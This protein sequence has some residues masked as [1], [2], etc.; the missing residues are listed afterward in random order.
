MWTSSGP[1]PRRDKYEALSQVWRWSARC[2]FNRRATIIC[3]EAAPYDPRGDSPSFGR[4]DRRIGP[5]KNLPWREKIR[6]WAEIVRNVP[7]GTPILL[8]DIDLAFFGNPFPD[9]EDFEPF[10]IGLCNRCTGAVYFS[11]SPASHSFMDWW[12]LETEELFR[13]EDLYIA[14]DRRY[15]GLDQC[16]FQLAAAVG[17]HGAKIIELPNRFHSTFQHHEL[18]AYVF[19]FHGKMR[20]MVLGTVPIEEIPQPLRKYCHDWQR[21]YKRAQTCDQ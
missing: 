3:H 9:L 4:G 12:L 17:A 21:M 11:G 8:T 20:G 13:N 15:L 1:G 14:L 19:H 6:H 2:T 5:S 18:P 16:S 7:I 10:D